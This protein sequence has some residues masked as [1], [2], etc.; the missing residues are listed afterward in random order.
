MT[1]FKGFF[2]CASVFAKS[3]VEM[4]LSLSYVL[5]LAS[6]ALYHVQYMMRFEDEHVM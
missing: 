6:G 1:L 5:Y 4:L 2:D 3:V